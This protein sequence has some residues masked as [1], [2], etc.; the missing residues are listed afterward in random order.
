MEE[1]YQQ[2]DDERRAGRTPL[3]SMDRT[4]PH[5]KPD[6]QVGFISN[7]CIPCYGLLSELMPGARPLLDGCVTNVERWKLLVSPE[8]EHRAGEARSSDSRGSL[9]RAAS[10]PV[11]FDPD[12]AD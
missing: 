10:L 4:K 11:R 3:P 12:A 8:S 7:I 9:S 5:L 2:G 1:F 6:I